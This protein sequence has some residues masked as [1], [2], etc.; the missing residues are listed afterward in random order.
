MSAERENGR[1]LDKALDELFDI[2]KMS[3]NDLISDGLM[4][5]LLHRV[6]R[7]RVYESEF[8]ER[9]DIM[10]VDRNDQLLLIM[11]KLYITTGF[12]TYWAG[13]DLDKIFFIVGKDSK[14]AYAKRFKAGFPNDSLSESGPQ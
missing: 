4:W 2:K 10:Q 3:E 12:K 8:V 9:Y 13:T 14:T 5:T 11:N 1:S 6:Q 7:D